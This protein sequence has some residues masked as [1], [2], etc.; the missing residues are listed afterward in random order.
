MSTCTETNDAMDTNNA[1]ITVAVVIPL[2]MVAV[3]ST[4]IV[5]CI[6]V[7]QKSQKLNNRINIM[8]GKVKRYYKPRPHS[9]SHARSDVHSATELTLNMESQIYDSEMNQIGS[10][11][12]KQNMA[13]GAKRSTISQQNEAYG[14]H[15]GVKRST[16]TQQNEAYGLTKTGT[17][18]LASG[19]TKQPDTGQDSDEYSYVRFQTR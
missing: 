4:L 10:G 1:E 5:V 8:C 9:L 3:V 19:N 18:A 12:T 11:E 13:G 16:V 17:T 15:G 7:C 6:I 2:L 14:I